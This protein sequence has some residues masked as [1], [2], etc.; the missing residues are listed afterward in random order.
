MKEIDADNIEKSFFE[1]EKGLTSNGIAPLDAY[2][3]DDG[4]VDYKSGFWSFN[5]KFP[6]QLYDISQITA[7]LDSHFGLWLG[8]R[9]GYGFP[10]KFAKKMEKLG[11]GSFNSEAKDVCVADKTYIKN[12]TDFILKSTKEFDIDYWKFDGF[13]LA[14]CKNPNHNH[15]VGGENDMYFITDMWECWI[16]VF[17]KIRELRTKAGKGLW[18]N[19][20]CYVNPSPWWLQYVNSIWVQNSADIGFADNL[21][22]ERYLLYVIGMAHP[23]YRL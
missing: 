23:A 22:A 5:K 18:I 2:V 19:M 4:W 3:V 17:K 7:K 16:D 11:K 13:C 14:P 6:N 1:I 20:T 12:V 21:K 9:G 8:P 10:D 15:P